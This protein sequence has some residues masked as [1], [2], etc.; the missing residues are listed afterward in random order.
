MTGRRSLRW[1]RSFGSRCAG[2]GG[3]RGGRGGLLSNLSS[4]LPR[5]VA[6]LGGPAVARWALAGKQFHRGFARHVPGRVVRREKRKAAAMAAWSSLAS[7]YRPG[8]PRVW[9]WP[10]YRGLVRR[11]G[12]SVA[13]QRGRRR[14]R[15]R[16]AGGATGFSRG[17]PRCARRPRQ[18]SHAAIDYG[19]RGRRPGKRRA[20]RMA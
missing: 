12:A 3:L 6:R 1:M 17:R 9:G 8:R 15:V 11:S 5:V 14:Y 4:C 10:R 2:H 13:G 20:R 18:E 7:A 16:R 19:R